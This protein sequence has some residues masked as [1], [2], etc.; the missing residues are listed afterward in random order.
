MNS[1]EFQKKLD[2]AWIEI[3]NK[4]K[5]DEKFLEGAAVKAHD[6]YWFTLNKNYLPGIIINIEKL[7]IKN[8]KF[9][10]AKGWS[11]NF[12]NKKIT[13]SVNEDK[14]KDFFV[15]LINLI[16]IK[17]YLEKLNG[18][19]SI[20]CFLKNLIFAKDFFEEENVPRKLTAEEQIGLFGE[21]QILKEILG[22]KFN[23]G[24]SLSSWTGPS[25]KHDFT[26]PNTL[27][28]IKTTST[29]TKKINTS[30]TNQIAP[31]YDK[32]LKLIFVQIKKNINGL[33]LHEV[34]DNY[35]KIL[36]E[37]SELLFNDFILKLTQCRYLDIHKSEYKQKYKIDKLNFFN[38]NENFPY[39]KEYVVPD[40][41]SDLSITYKIDLEKCEDFRINEEELINNL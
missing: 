22:K 23:L 12:H 33:S 9:P 30:S 27:L 19:K 39:I 4:R 5:K 18:E 14:Y 15:K 16:L 37:E 8:N 6:N 38:I 13:M 36:K 26:L 10:K 20:N 2:N 40:G 29:D 31:V 21:I 1:I 3:L 32:K 17:V 7:N 24:T 25:K 41:L 11:F 28:E 35:S 34:I